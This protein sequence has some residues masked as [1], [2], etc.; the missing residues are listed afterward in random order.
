MSFRAGASKVDMTAF[1]PG[2]GMMGY[3]QEHNVVG[4]IGTRLWARALFLE[5]PEG[6]QLLLVHL[7]QCFV[8][9]LVKEEIL[10]RLATMFPDLRITGDNFL[11]TA[12]H[13]H[14]APGGYTDSP[15]FNFFVPGFQPAVF[16]KIVSSALEAID[17]AQRSLRPVTLS[18]GE[19]TVPDQLEVA[20]NRS[21]SAHLRNPEASHL[22]EEDTHLLVD[23]TMKGLKVTS[24]EGATI[25]VLN[26]FGVHATSISSYNDLIHHDNKGIAA[27]LY[28]EAEPGAIAFFLQLTAGDVSPNFIWDRALKRMRGKFSDQYASAEFNGELQFREAKRM[29]YDRSLEGRLRCE[30]RFFDLGRLACAPAHGVAFFK[31]T[32]EG[33]GLPSFL[34][35]ALEG[36]SDLVK[37][38][39][40]ARSEESNRSFYQAQSPKKVGFD[41]RNNRLLGI[42]ASWWALLPD[43]QELTLRKMK[44]EMASYQRSP[45]SWA[46]TSV[47]LQLLQIGPLLLVAVP[48]EITTIAGLRLRNLLRERL[49][50]AGVQEVIVTSYANDYLGYITTPEEYE[51]QCYEGGHTIY[52]RNTLPVLLECYSELATYLQ[53]PT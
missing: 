47:P 53:A 36:I 31:G 5:D 2:I 35:P 16:E 9:I 11:L 37:K 38:F 49:A 14:S 28:E 18:L 52:G 39:D 30:Q 7:E 6:S 15:F 41:H 29:T 13:T 8:T 48:G 4:S 17:L 40:L 27:R 21:P 1:V 46:P 43:S 44:K 25:A 20:F 51:A 26:W 19:L 23:R 34:I 32:L 3:G 45:K 33:P 10:R 24:Q 12:Q 50:T 22:S 42:P